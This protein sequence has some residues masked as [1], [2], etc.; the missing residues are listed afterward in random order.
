MPSVA[1]FTILALAPFAPNAPEGYKPRV[2]EADLYSLDD[3]VAAVAPRFWIDVPKDAC[4]E[5]G[6]T[7]AI[8]RLADFKPSGIVAGTPYLADLLAAR[9]YLRAARSANTAPDEA[10]AHIR[11]SWPGLPLDLSVSPAREAPQASSAVDDILSMVATEASPQPSG[12]G[13]G[14]TSWQAQSETLLSRCLAAVF[15]D[16]AFKASEAAW[17][18]AECL[19]RKAGIK[20]GGRVRVKLVS[21]GPETLEAALAGLMAELAADVPHLTVIDHAFDNTPASL[22]LLN[23]VAAYADALLAPTA[24]ELSPVFFRLDG[25]EQ[26][27]R[28]GYLPHAL[29]DAAFAKFRKLREHPGASRLCALVNRFLTRAPYGP[30]NPAR[31]VAFVEAGELWLSPV[32]GLATL[33]AKSVAGHGW[34]TRFTDSMEIRVEELAVAGSGQG[35]AP[36]R[37]LFGENQ[38]AELIESGITPL[39]SAKGKDYAIIPRQTCLDGGSLTFQ[40]FFGRVV[41]F[42]LDRREQAGAEA[43]AKASADPAGYVRAALFELFNQTDQT[44][45]PDLTVGA[46]EA[47]DGRVGLTISFTPPRQVMGGERLSFTFGW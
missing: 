6:L 45:P 17:R 10:A 38:I 34:P 5:G 37:G 39:L 40:L 41:S 13:G 25:W 42:L 21:S 4:P 32:W 3:A 31:P 35:P 26:L 7:V 1:P 14:L 33:C 9:E 11:S 44:P 15:A 27:S 30:G 19:A 43:D 20:Q 16:P 24:V 22:E 29:E 23:A 36:T 28:L 12:G 8:T 2:A 18:G 47:K 46:A